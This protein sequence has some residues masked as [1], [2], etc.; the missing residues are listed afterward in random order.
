LTRL[1]GCDKLNLSG[2]GD[3][4][5]KGKIKMAKTIYTLVEKVSGDWELVYKDGVQ[6]RGANREEVVAVAYTY[7]YPDQFRV[8]ETLED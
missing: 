7:K 4:I 1:G 8:I 5:E 6:V 2:Q 3:L